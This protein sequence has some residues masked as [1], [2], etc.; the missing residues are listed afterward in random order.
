MFTRFMLDILY[1]LENIQVIVS[2]KD[3]ELRDRHPE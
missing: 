1:V 3:N 2:W